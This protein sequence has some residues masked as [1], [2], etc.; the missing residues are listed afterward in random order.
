MRTGRSGLELLLGLGHLGAGTGLHKVVQDLLRSG[1][2]A[3]LPFL[4]RRA[5]I[6]MLDRLP[7]LDPSGSADVD[8]ILVMMA[9]AVVLQAQ[10][11]PG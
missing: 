4:D 3:D 9:S 1:A 11:R 5:A 8:P 10:L 7:R 2:A 6:S